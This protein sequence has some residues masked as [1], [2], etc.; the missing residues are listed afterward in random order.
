MSLR[1]YTI[2]ALVIAASAAPVAAQSTARDA[3]PAFAGMGIIP[4]TVIDSM[5]AVA[6]NTTASTEA[7]F[8]TADGTRGPSLASARVAAVHRT[9]TRVAPPVIQKRPS[10]HNSV[11]LM[12]V[13]GAALVVGSVIN[14]DAGT[15]IMVGGAAIGLYGLYEFLT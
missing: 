9:D 6:T 10:H 13:G 15:L 11:V 12:I 8:A 2:T 7:S 3:S 1:F 4:N 5:T 14:G